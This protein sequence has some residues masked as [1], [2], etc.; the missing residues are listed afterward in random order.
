MENVWE[1]ILLD[2]LDARTYRSLNKSTY[3]KKIN[4]I[5]SAS[6]TESELVDAIRHAERTGEDHLSYTY[7][8][9]NYISELTT[10]IISTN[11]PDQSI[12][13]TSDGSIFTTNES[14]AFDEV[15]WERHI[16]RH[17][18][19]INQKNTSIGISRFRLVC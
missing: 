8:M 1:D 3:M 13:I 19:N 5:L 6:V 11:V 9:E 14:T 17:V 7:I 16:G 18:E 10:Y 4:N 2:V 15:P 12:D